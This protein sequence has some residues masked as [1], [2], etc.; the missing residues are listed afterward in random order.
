MA[1]GSR[2]AGAAR[3]E[4]HRGWLPGA[5][6][7][8]TERRRARTPRPRSPHRRGPRTRTS[9]RGSRA[10]R[11]PPS[12]RSRPSSR[13]HPW[14]PGRPRR[15]LRR[16]APLTELQ[17]LIPILVNGGGASPQVVRG[18]D[19]VANG[20]AQAMAFSR[21]L[22]R[23]GAT[24][25][26]FEGAVELLLLRDAGGPRTCAFA[27]WP[28]EKLADAFVAAG[29]EID[30]GVRVATRT[31]AD[32]TVRRLR[33]SG[34]LGTAGRP[35]GRPARCRLRLLGA[36]RSAGERRRDHRLHAPAAARAA[37]APDDRRPADPADVSAGVRVDPGRRHVLVRLSGRRRRAGS[38]RRRPRRADRLCVCHL[39]D[40]R[41]P[42][43]RVPRPRCLE[44]GSCSRPG[45][46]RSARA[47]RRPVGRSG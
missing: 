42:G 31:V 7:V 44:R 19:L 11:V 18:E 25:D 45:S 13:C 15:P 28:R 1:S 23:L 39:A 47:S 37:P 29:K 14:H 9:W 4:H 6:R 2:G 27:A 38:E 10:R 24:P 12:S 8:A 26:Q 16:P 22:D 41:C 33:L 20:D 35:P 17:Q 32:T 40:R 43:H 3:G 34:G 30:P 21:M 5:G 46:P 36:G